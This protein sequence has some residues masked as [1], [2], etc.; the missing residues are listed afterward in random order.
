MFTVRGRIVSVTPRSDGT[1]GVTV[2]PAPELFW[3]TTRA[4]APKLGADVTLLADRVTAI[5]KLT[6][7]STQAT[8]TTLEGVRPHPDVATR[9]PVGR[10]LAPV[11]FERVRTTMKRPL[12]AYQE[13]GAA[14][15]ASLL[16]TGG[17]AILADEPGTGKTCT[18]IAAL[19]ATGLFPV[20][21]V[22]TKSLLRNWEREVKYANRELS[23]AIV[24]SRKATLPKADVLI[25]TYQ[26][27]R[28]LEPAI[29]RMG[30]RAIVF[31]E[32]HLIKEPRPNTKHHRAAV[33][34][35]L[36]LWIGRVV[37][38]TGS[39]VLN[40]PSELWRLL[41]ICDPRNWPDFAS[42]SERYCKAPTPE[43][44]ACAPRDQRRIVT[45][46]GRVEHVDE[47]QA[48][49]APTMLRRLTSDVMAD[50]PPKSR[51]SILIELDEADLRNYR[52]AEKNIVAWL[53]AQGN[54]L[55][56]SRAKH[57]EALV[58]LTH[59]RRL[60][61]EAKLKQA[62][63]EYLRQWFDRPTAPPLLIF[64]YFMAVGNGLVAICEQ[65]GLRVATIRGKD[66][67]TKRQDAIDAF[68]AGHADVFVAP[69]KAAGVG[70]NLQHA[71]DVLFTERHW[72]TKEMEQA[73]SRSHRLG[74]TR[75][76]TVTYL[77]AADTIDEDVARV[78]ASKGALVDALVDN[79][80][81]SGGDFAAADEVLK[82]YTAKRAPG[83]LTQ[84]PVTGIVTAHP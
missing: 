81:G 66:S 48:L 40:R 22:A 82:S 36:G 6:K 17:G 49:V 3:Y 68:A 44:A 71:A 53:K 59:L 15:L 77:D 11:W 18:T 76:V 1:F 12:R 24:R 34:T 58:R 4:P 25:T 8:L 37:A 64:H 45:T 51:H 39:P 10:V 60:V 28:A 30:A 83:V 47:L 42:F 67:D 27:L 31:D 43:E 50:L 23:V 13:E 61:G 80:F 29:V 9:S 7:T 75:P 57:A 55:A 62:L 54:E 5:R 72:V 38:L 16:A 63:P 74:Q 56:S 84:S 33:A 32:A 70:I 35:R 79:R 52:E 69:I 2:G 73:E 14:W 46:T 21:V 41:H 65:L 26:L 19:C 78:N 20:V